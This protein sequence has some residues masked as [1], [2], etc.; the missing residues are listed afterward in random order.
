MPAGEVQPATEIVFYNWS[1]YID[2][3]IY[4]L[5]EAETGIKVVEDNFSSNEEQP[6]TTDLQRLKSNGRE[7]S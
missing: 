1:E 2:S 3:E 6:C 7:G 5:F 4:A